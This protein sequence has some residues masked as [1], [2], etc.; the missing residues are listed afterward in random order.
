MNA[1]FM[2]FQGKDYV[3]YT[4]HKIKTGKDYDKIAGY[5]SCIFNYLPLDEIK[6][7]VRGK[8]S[9]VSVGEPQVLNG[10]VWRFFTGVHEQYG[11]SF[12]PYEDCKEVYI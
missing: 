4:S 6:E 1:Y 5:F 2:S 3:F 7:W 8:V 11:G 12:T 9:F 10:K